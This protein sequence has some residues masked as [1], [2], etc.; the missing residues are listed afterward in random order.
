M[1]SKEISEAG[2]ACAQALLSNCQ[3]RLEAGYQEKTAF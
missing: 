2:K 3:R 1:I